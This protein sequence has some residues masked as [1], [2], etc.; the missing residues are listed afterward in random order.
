M[1]SWESVN[2]ETDFH[3]QRHFAEY[4]L[5]ADNSVTFRFLL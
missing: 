5:M 1:D 3:Q 4:Q 2:T